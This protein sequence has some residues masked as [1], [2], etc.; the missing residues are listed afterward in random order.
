MYFFCSETVFKVY[1]K[2]IFS[3]LNYIWRL[4]SKR[5]AVTRKLLLVKIGCESLCLL[6]LLDE[7]VMIWRGRWDIPR[8]HVVV[9]VDKE[10]LCGRGGIWRVQNVFRQ[11]RGHQKM[12]PGV[13]GGARESWVAKRTNKGAMGSQ[14]ALV[15][16]GL[17]NYWS[18][19]CTP[20]T[21]LTRP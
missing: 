5:R 15:P 3:V 2:C 16:A 14:M 19:C 20:I 17:Y 6:L 21:G 12:I 4:S 9:E 7:P 8:G 1:P 10:S 13:Q 11:T 18:S